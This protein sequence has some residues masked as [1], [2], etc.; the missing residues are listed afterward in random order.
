MELRSAPD[1]RVVSNVWYG[2]PL[3]AELFDRP[4]GGYVSAV[5]SAVRL[6][7]AAGRNGVVVTSEGAARPIGIIALALAY[8]V[9]RRR[10][11]VILEFLP[12]LK[13]G[14]AGSAVR[15]FYR[16]LL[17][18]ACLSI[19]VMTS[20]E[21]ALYIEEY[22]LDPAS[23]THVP[24]YFY[25]DSSHRQL[26][27]DSAR[28]GVFASGRSSC[29]WDL[30]IAAARGRSWNLTIV[31][32]AEDHDDVVKSAAGT[33]IVIRTEI[34]EDEHADL[35]AAARVYVITLE[36]RPVSAGHVRIM[37]AA[38]FETPVVVTDVR[39]L[40]GYKHLAAEVVPAGDVEQLRSAVERL[41]NDPDSRERER[42]RVRAIAR[43]NTRTDYLASIER[44]LNPGEASSLAQQSS[45]T[46][47]A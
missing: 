32:S 47:R 3:G 17:R 40:D 26:T 25:D 10:G 41:L 34:S 11:L 5:V 44:L 7:S 36:D 33:D 19:Q 16:R 29:D 45:N 23:V 28:T 20:W 42:A 35:L 21:R 22:D 43:S 24:F 2:E 13:T 31:C 39:G 14:R 18:R 1:R 6:L 46:A 15:F 9:R 8:A 30:L 12:G 38:T 27:P 37:G 4:S